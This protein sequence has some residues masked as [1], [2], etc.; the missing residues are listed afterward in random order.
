M[1]GERFES[2]WDAIEDD[3]AI[4]EN[5]K[6]RSSLMLA[7]TRHIQKEG[8]TQAH[9]AEA[10]GVSQPRVSNLMRGKIGAF[11]LDLLVKMAVAVGLRVTMRL[12]KAA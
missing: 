6:L 12:T 10:L 8:W 1:T 2:V 9:A 5:L 7:L 11:S 4:V 3:P